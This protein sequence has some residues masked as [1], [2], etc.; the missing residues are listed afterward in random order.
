MTCVVVCIHL[1]Y[2]A[3]QLENGGGGKPRTRLA[4]W[5]DVTYTGRSVLLNYV[6]TGRSV[7]LN[8]V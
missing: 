5:S 7:L 4:Y 6:Y 2:G 3:A 8:Y 1:L